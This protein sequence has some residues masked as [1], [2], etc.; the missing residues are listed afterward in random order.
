MIQAQKAMEDLIQAT[1]WKNTE[2]IMLQAARHKGHILPGLHVVRCPDSA[3][4]SRQQAGAAVSEEGRKDWGWG[5]LVGTGFCFG[6]A[7]NVLELV[8]MTVQLS[9]Y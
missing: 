4:P 5:L 3:N 7:K 9:V 6:G 1:V 2:H 8:V